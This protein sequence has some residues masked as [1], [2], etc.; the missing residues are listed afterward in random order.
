MD[1]LIQRIHDS[2]PAEGFSEVLVAGEPESRIEAIRRKRGI[3]YTVSD[4]IAL[5]EE[6]AKAGLPALRLLDNLRENA[7]SN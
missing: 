2:P 1:T 3:P 7:A 6:A 4:L 5:N